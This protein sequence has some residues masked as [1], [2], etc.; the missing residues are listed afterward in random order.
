ML[1]Y[2]SPPTLSSILSQFDH[3]CKG[4]DTRDWTMDGW[5]R[6]DNMS[7]AVYIDDETNRVCYSWEDPDYGDNNPIDELPQIMN[8]IAVRDEWEFHSMYKLNQR[9]YASR[10][11]C[12]TKEQWLV[13]WGNRAFP[14][15]MVWRVDP[16]SYVNGYYLGVPTFSQLLI[17]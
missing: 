9:L 12:A 5:R 7:H 14:I 1:A 16:S 3:K 11:F 10:V 17:E 13:I 8:P 2:L 4:F 15:A 6:I